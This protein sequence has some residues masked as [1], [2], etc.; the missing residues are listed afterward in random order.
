LPV[1]AAGVVLNGVCVGIALSGVELH[2]FAIA[3]CVLGIGWNFLFTG[4]TTLS[5]SAYAADERDRAQAAMN[6]LLFAVMAISSFSSGVLVTT[7][8]WT[9][10]NLG[11]LVPLLLIA[12]GLLWLGRH[13]RALRPKPLTTLTQPAPLRRGG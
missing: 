10:L 6:F 8:G 12:A 2:H 13:R 5:L 7:Q 3:L 1:M 9:L 11:S 4:A